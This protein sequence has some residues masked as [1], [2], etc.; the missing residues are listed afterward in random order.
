MLKKAPVFPSKLESAQNI[1]QIR[2]DSEPQHLVVLPRNLTEH[3]AL[4]LVV[5]R[6]PGGS[7][8]A[9]SIWMKGNPSKIPDPPIFPAHAQEARIFFLAECVNHLYVAVQQR[10]GPERFRSYAP[11]PAATL[12]HD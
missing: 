6:D 11:G 4:S 7:C 5:H 10:V 1:L 3:Q 8:P 2:N 12:P 9:A